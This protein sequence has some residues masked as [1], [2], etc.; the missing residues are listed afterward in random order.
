MKKLIKGPS[1]LVW[2][3]DSHSLLEDAYIVLEDDS[4]RSW[5]ELGQLEKKDR[6]FDK[7]I[8][9]DNYFVCPGF[10]NI[11]SHV[12]NQPTRKGFGNDWG[13][14]NF[15]GSALYDNS[16]LFELSKEESKIC[17]THSIAEMLK[18]G[19][20]TMVEMGNNSQWYEDAVNNLGMR[21]Y[22]VPGYRSSSW[23][24]I[25]GRKVAY[26]WDE[27][28]GREEMKK[29][30]EYVKKCN[31]DPNSKINSMLGPAQID[32]CTEELLRK[33]AE[34]AEELDC[35]IHI[36]AA[37]TLK[38]FEIILERHGLTPIE[39]LKE[40]GI[41]GENC[42]IA[43]SVFTNEHPATNYPYG[44]DLELLSE[45]GSHIAHCPWVF[46]RSGDILHSF[47]KYLEEGINMGMGTD[48]NP[49]DI[50][51]EMKWAAVGSKIA[52]RNFASVTVEDVVNAATIGGAEALGRDDLGKIAP[53][54]K[55]DMIF[56]DLDD[57]DMSPTRDPVKNF[58]YLAGSKAIDKVMVDGEFVVEDGTVK[59]ID[60][61]KITD[62][63]REVAERVWE[64]IPE[65]DEEGRT[66]DEIY[67]R[68]FLD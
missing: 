14:E 17:G 56:V 34:K 15:Y 37:Q 8:E 42:I 43:H 6:E 50:T 53:G 41:L 16:G 3:D 22:L 63:V 49:L 31:S 13:N 4:I 11:H 59:N 33:T 30:V 2:K 67:P 62:E 7:T 32:T 57:F 9:A 38:E 29:N 55:A 5:G 52:D 28:S 35:R 61:G 60:E 27:E 39:Y 47:G 45:S 24:S 19:T 48:T 10:L 1:A 23:D 54:G 36:H 65:N 40:T 68:A 64:D 18:K 21:A 12:Y 66:A 51:A 20:T 26:N 44:D 46:A 58:I 25:E